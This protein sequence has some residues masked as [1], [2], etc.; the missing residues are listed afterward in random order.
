MF[1][2]LPIGF[3]KVFHRFPWANIG[4]MA[5]CVALF[6]LRVATPEGEWFERLT[7]YPSTVQAPAELEDDPDVAEIVADLESHGWT[8]QPWSLFTYALLHED[9][10]HLAGNMMFLCVFGCASTANWATCAT[11]SFGPPP[12]SLRG[13]GI[14]FSAMPALLAPVAR[15]VE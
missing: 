8:K 6:G 1:F 3:L 13:L 15:S 9:F 10:F 7:L 14:C 12:R 4:L 11:C 2:I 5:V